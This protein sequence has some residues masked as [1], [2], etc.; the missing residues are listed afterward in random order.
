MATQGTSAKP[1]NSSPPPTPWQWN[2]SLDTPRD[3]IGYGPSPPDPEWPHKA[4]LA[5]S[6]VL[7]YEEGGEYA[8]LN[9]DSHSETYLTE[10]AGGGTPKQEAR[11]TNSESIFEYGARAGIWRLLKVFENAGVKGTVYGVGRAHEQN[12]LVAKKLVEMGW[13]MGCHGWR[14][15]DYSDYS[16]ADEREDIIRCIELFQKQAGR[17]PPGWYVGRLSARSHELLRQIYKERGLELLWL[18]DYYGDDLP[19]WHPHPEGEGSGAQLVIPY[20]LDNNDFRYSMPNNWSSPDDFYGYLVKSFDELYA[21]GEEG[22]PK[23]MSVGLHGRLSG[24][25]GRVGAVRK[26]VEYVQSKGEGNVW[27]ATREEIARHWMDVHPHSSA[28]AS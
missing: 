15:I 16:E 1:T 28:Q 20:T 23:M 12:P 27:I 7:D 5:L 8:V 10:S 18:S 4:K 19:F 3:L 14:W 25:P 6:F 11:D 17:A 24:R 9:G 21:E 26:F 2:P 22:S 13:E